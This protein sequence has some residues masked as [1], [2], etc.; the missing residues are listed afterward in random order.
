[1]EN[2]NKKILI[3][4]DDAFLREFYQDLLVGEGYMVDIAQDGD[5]AWSKINQG[6]WDLILLD[7][8]LPKKD[9][10]QILKDLNIKSSP[11]SVGPIVVLSNLGSDSVIKDAFNFGAAGYL[12]KSA[13][14]PE[15]VLANIHNF[16]GQAKK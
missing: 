8:M 9:G 5:I 7:I 15:E 2:A 10:L 11:T 3:V 1:M 16:L 13:M 12:I 14:N 6:S 4:E